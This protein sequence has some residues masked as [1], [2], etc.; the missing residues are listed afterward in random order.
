MPVAALSSWR[1]VGLTVGL[2]IGIIGFGAQ[3]ATPPDADLPPP[4]MPGVAIPA[5]QIDMAITKL[6]G[7]A[8]DYL[9]TT[10]IPG[11][12]IAVVRDGTTVYAKG[13]GVRRA[14][15]PERV[16]ADTVFQLASLSKSVGATVI[17][18]EVGLHVVE[19]DTPIVRHLPWFALRDG[20]VTQHV[21]IADMYAHRSGLADHAGDDLEELGYD[22][23]Q[24]LQRLR[25][26]PLNPFRSTYEYTNFGVTAGAE[27]V[28]AAAGKDWAA[29]SQE[30]IYG[31]LGMTS[32][33]SRFSDFESREDR[34]VGHVRVGG[35]FQPKYQR[36]P[37]AQ[38]PAGG[39]SSSVR[40]MARWMAMVL[41][42]GVYEGKPIVA[43]DALMPAVTAEIVSGHAPSMTARPSLYGYGFG[44]VAQ[45]SGR[46]ALSHSGAFGLGAATCYVMIP[47]AGIG[48]V[49][50]SNAAPMGAVEALAASFADLVQFGSVTRDWLTAYGRAFA[51]MNAPL[52]ALQGKEPPANPAPPAALKTYA[53][54][55][56]NAYFGDARILL[57]GDALVLRIGPAGMEFPLRH[58]D[59]N[60]FVYTPRGE[61]AP[62]GSISRID[63]TLNKS[64]A[65]RSLAIEYYAP[66]GQGT[67][68]RKP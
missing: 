47:S 22:R 32:T 38:S 54:D 14:G 19:W 12:A 42:G 44:V 52:G 2:L 57:R 58:W 51:A 21:T 5:G 13:F 6:D 59:G 37:D 29:L 35:A 15:S 43:R 63:F 11:L 31:P 18:R 49:V 53:G 16:D 8:T 61:N 3:A 48:I 33:S 28:A 56:A 68:T 50:L 45:P 39:V 7:L 23:R 17:A 30:A 65:A 66:S 60:V 46:M 27:A 9:R 20:W 67:F 62:D 41:Q 36:Q 64:G 1:R 10:G 25:L 40:D 4:E 24:V 26:L 34:A 55:Y